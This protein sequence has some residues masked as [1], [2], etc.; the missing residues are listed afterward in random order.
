VYYATVNQPVTNAFAS[1]SIMQTLARSPNVF[2]S[3]PSSLSPNI[4]EHVMDGERVKERGD[5][6]EMKKEVN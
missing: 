5:G 4:F 2:L 6:G 3:L 1:G